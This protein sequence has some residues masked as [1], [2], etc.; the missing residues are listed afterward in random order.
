MCGRIAL[1]FGVL[2]ASV[3]MQARAD[4]FELAKWKIQS[5]DVLTQRDGAAISTPGFPTDGWYAVDGP[6]TVVAAMIADGRYGDPF[7]GMNLRKLPGTDYPIGKDYTTLPMTETSPF[8]ASWWYKN[9]FTLRQGSGRVWL[10]LNGLNFRANVWVNGKKIADEF[11]TRGPFRRW[12]W[13]ITDVANVGGPNAV[14]I[15]LFASTPDDLALT[16]IDWSPTPADK[17]LGL[18]NEAF[19]VR[20]GPVRLRHPYVQSDLDLP[21]DWGKQQYDSLGRALAKLNRLADD[22][23]EK[24]EPIQKEQK[25]IL[26]NPALAGKV[27][28]FE[29]AGYV[30]SGMYRPCIDCRMFSL[31]LTDFDPVC[32]AAIIRQIDFYSH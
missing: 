17:N 1:F 14:A 30:S 4:S 18:L 21:T 8:R 22:Y 31:S 32:K 24:R 9:D 13:D 29:G 5:S 16:W 11:F 28:A 19:V 20:T 27:G 3:A 6:S 12:E 10:K 26:S 7:V 25:A 2:L 23:Y 15:E